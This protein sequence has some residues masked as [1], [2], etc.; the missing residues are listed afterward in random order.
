[1]KSKVVYEVPSLEKQIA[2]FK[3]F[4]DI[5][6]KFKNSLYLEYPDL[7]DNDFREYVSS[8][9]KS[10]IEELEGIKREAQANWS[11][12]EESVL[13]EFS[14]I[15]QK[16]WLFETIQGGIS[17]LPFSTRDLK[18][19]R[20]DVYYKKDLQGILKTTT[21]ELFHF[22]YFEKWKDIFPETTLEEMDY[23]NP[24]W[25]LSEIA[26]PMMLNDSK[27]IEIL[28][29]SFKN[30][31]MFENEMFNGESITGHIENI[32]ENGTLEDSLKES[33]E[34]IEKYYQFRNKSMK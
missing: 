31:G 32:F 9:Y 24:I 26:L 27:V 19:K 13:K 3:Y 22:I 14:N 25:T 7:K 8:L 12:V 16:E 21:H 23:P 17:L 11:G 6:E 20:F 30:Y 18:E 33:H 2:L 10:K 15:L 1:M 28:G 4:I 29:V 34:Y 5:D